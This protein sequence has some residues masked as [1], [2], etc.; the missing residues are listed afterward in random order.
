MK[1]SVNWLRE[2]VDF[3]D[4]V[5][6]L[7]E[8]LTLL[9]L[10]VEAVEP[11]SLT[12]PEVVVGHVLEARPHPDADRLRVC[13]VSVGDEELG[14]VCGA[15]NVRAG[16]RVAVAKI[17]AV[18][19]GDFRIRK[20]KIRGQVSMGMICSEKELGLGEGH[21]GILELEGEPEVGRPLDDLFGV[22]DTVIEIEVTPNRPDW[23]SHI[24][25]A[26]EIA[27]FY[28]KPLRLPAIPEAVHEREV[29]ARDQGWTVRIL[30][31][32]GAR[33]FRAR[34]IDG[35]E[36]GPSPLWLRQRLLALGQRPINAV[37]DA[38]NLVL[39]ECGHPNHCFD[40]DKIQGQE[41]VLRRAREGEE[42]RTLD[43]VQR[44][45]HDHHLLV[46]DARGGIALAGIMGGA[47]SEVDATTQNLL[48]EVAV[49]DP[50]V[51][52]RGR[53]S[54]GL[55]TDASYRFERGVD[56]EAVPWVSR[57]LAGLIQELSGGTVH[58][59]AVE[60]IGDPP[61][62][63]APFF[64][65]GPRCQRL[66]G[67]DVGVDRIESILDSLE[68]GTRRARVDG[69]EGV[70]VDPP[71]FRHDL[72]Q[73]VDAIEE[74]A[75]LHGFDRLDA[76]RRP[77]QAAPATRS[78]RERFRRRLRDLLSARAF[79]EVMGSSF[80]PQAELDALGLDA[81]DRRRRA[82]HVLNPVVQGESMLKTTAVA[83]MAGFV[84]R[85]R[86][87]GHTGPVRL[88]QLARCFEAVEGEPLPREHE[89]LLLA[90]AGP[91]APLHPDHDDAR[92]AVD[93]LDAFG[94]IDA[95]LDQLGI[96]FERRGAPAESWQ[97]EGTV[98]AWTTPAGTLGTVSEMAP[99]VRRRLDVETAVLIAA[100]DLEALVEALPASRSCRPISAYPPV[101]RDLSLV[102]PAG[103]QWA[104]I[105][106]TVRAS[107]GILLENA[108]LF[109]VYEGEGLP[110]GTRALGVRLCLRSPSGTLKDKKVDGLLSKLL[111]EL[112][113]T[114]Q[115][116]LRTEIEGQG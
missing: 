53:R 22:R 94:E 38:S 44:R 66:L 47:D 80:R 14:I 65:R 111:D 42:F 39:H 108:E 1:L 17:G 70:W 109:D 28:A 7:C 90:L 9:G 85:N 25:V 4:D 102:V 58:P 29:A 3:P 83:E 101:R 100:F 84:E 71:S 69:V 26:R 43:D 110:S 77:L 19:P 5:E 15:P 98:A 51:I 86:R 96:A 16:L 8:R 63:P 54:V 23:L 57:R 103:V 82:V 21:E 113:S 10:E 2:F 61:A 107:L 11:F 31:P 40:R 93:L 46:A 60:A 91:A 87:R 72:H 6:A 116:R 12:F 27:A 68:I 56:F 50:Q 37:V 79:H 95:I 20:S 89:E 36:V 34:L 59:V 64:V 105:V 104:E 52:R 62:R 41:I 45:L 99:A 30:D 76:A 32:S 55:S 92:R 33:R 24:G 48:L 35:V 81:G 106:R 74:V 13:R 49:F 115:I 88:F 97:R 114:H 75:R 67:L 73:E 78:A 18:L 112:R